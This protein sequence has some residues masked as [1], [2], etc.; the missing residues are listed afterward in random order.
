M[1]RPNHRR[2]EGLEPR[3]KLT[4]AMVDGEPVV[5]CGQER[6]IDTL[7]ATASN[8]GLWVARTWAITATMG[9]HPG[10]EVGSAEQRDL[11][12]L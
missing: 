8:I 2:I 9:F 7:L 1:W 3:H 6:D 11:L 12:S 4:I 5:W 10:D